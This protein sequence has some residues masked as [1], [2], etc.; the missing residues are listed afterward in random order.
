MVLTF[1][2]GNLEKELLGMVHVTGTSP[3]HFTSNG[4]WEAEVLIVSRGGIVL[5]S[6]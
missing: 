6:S 1:F 4:S 3:T 2:I 5:I